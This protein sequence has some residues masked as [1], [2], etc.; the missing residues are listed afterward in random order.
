MQ[1]ITYINGLGESITSHI[2]TMF[3][4]KDIVYYVVLDRTGNPTIIEH[5]DLIGCSWEPSK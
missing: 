3:M 5:A 1:I 2:L 4:H